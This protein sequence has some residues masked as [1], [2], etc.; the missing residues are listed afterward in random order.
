MPQHW[1]SAMNSR[2][3]F[4]KA[5]ILSD[6]RSTLREI[7]NLELTFAGMRE[8]EWGIWESNRLFAHHELASL[9]STRAQIKILAGIAS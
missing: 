2:V 7:F 5:L 6:K 4:N 1:N 8:V 3:G 9:A